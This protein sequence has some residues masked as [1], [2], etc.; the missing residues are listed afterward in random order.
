MNNYHDILGI[1]HGASKSEIKKAYKRLAM[2]YHP[3]KN[4]GDPVYEEKMKKL[5]EAYSALIDPSSVKPKTGGGSSNWTDFTD[6]EANRGY[7]RTSDGESRK[8][9]FGGGFGGEDFRKMYNDLFGKRQNHYTQGFDIHGEN[10]V[11]FKKPDDITNT[12]HIESD[13]LGRRV[14]RNT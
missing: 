2:K 5:N 4:N 12:D 6:N 1:K 8:G 7:R 14:T 3:D 13:P 9:G 10:D 11:N